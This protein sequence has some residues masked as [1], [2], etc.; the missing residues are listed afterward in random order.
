MKRQLT[1]DNHIS[2]CICTYKRPQMLSKLLS[3]L[4]DQ[5]TINQF[6]YSVDIVDNDV[7]QSAKDIVKVWQ[8][9]STIQIDYYFE[10][11]Q[12]IALAR[13]KAVENAKGD[14]IAFIDDDESPEDTWLSNLFKAYHTYKCDGILGPVKPHFEGVPPTWLV[15]GKFCDRES[16]KTGMVL[17]WTQTR[18]GNVLINTNVFKDENKRFDPSLGRTGGEDIDFFKRMI[19]DGKSFV[20]CNEAVVFETVPPERWEKSFYLKK[21][22]QMGGRMGE[23]V[24]TWP[25]KLKCKWFVK[26]IFSISFYSVVLPFS[27]LG[28][29]HV[30]M[31]CIFK[32]LYYISWFIGFFWRPI[33]RFRY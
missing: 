25:L 26:A 33:I 7:N 13:N 15:C 21:Y 17:D 9:Q 23:I 30:L 32:D 5:V 29:Q 18:T 16:H 28:G 20:W 2:V 31:K 12:N 8:E 1:L 11:E 22:I 14:F 24:G 6:T 3:K 27:F 10:P 19:H 4:H